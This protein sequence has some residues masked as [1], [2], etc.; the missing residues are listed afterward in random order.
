V[1]AG[2]RAEA[3]ALKVFLD[4]KDRTP[5]YTDYVRTELAYVDYVLVREAADVHALVT[6][7]GTGAGGREY[8]IKFVGLGVFA[9]VDD[10]LLYVTLPTDT[11]ELARRGFVRTLKLGLVRYALHTQVGGELNV[12]HKAAGAGKRDPGAA[13][14]GKDPWNY[15]VFRGRANANADIESA[16]ESRQYSGAFS[17]N[18]IT[19]AWKFSV[20]TATDTRENIYTYSSGDTYTSKRRS[21][22]LT[23]QIVKSLG[24]HWAAGVKSFVAGSTYENKHQ[25]LN[26]SGAVEYNFFPYSESTRRQFTL[27]YVVG[28]TAY[29]YIEE[30]VYGKL[31]ETAPNHIFRASF[32]TRQ[33]WG[34][35]SADAEFSQF[36]HDTSQRRNSVQVEGDVRLFRGFSLNFNLRT[37][38]INDQIYLPKGDATDEEVLA[39]QRQLK[40]SFRHTIRVGISYTFGSIYSNVVNTR[41]SNFVGGGGGGDRF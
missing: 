40:T 6:S 36:L 26:A 16:N 38:R 13:R 5:C 23:G 11:E 39:R 41:L 12:T 15:W 33:T 37:A 25:V 32:D 7:R 22:D 3:S 1:A 9:G 2:A 14:S 24:D 27:Q 28:V 29:D 30:T 20:T 19:D 21:Y 17:A 4:C 35:I 18:R 8:T 31:S 10:E 34:S